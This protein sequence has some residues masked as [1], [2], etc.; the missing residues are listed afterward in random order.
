MLKFLAVT[1][2]LVVSSLAFAQDPNPT[3]PGPFKAEAEAGVIVV[4]GNTESESYAAKLLASYTDNGNTYS[5]FGKY[6]QAEANGLES[7]LNWNAG[8]RYERALSEH[9]SIYAGYK[10]ES[11]K[12]AGYLQRDSTDLGG[13]YYLVKQDDKTWTTELGYRYSKTLSTASEVSYDNYV[14]LYTEYNQSLDKTLSFKY[15]LEYLP[16]LT[17]NDQYLTNTEA[18][19]NVMLSQVFSL[20]LAYLLQYQN[21]P[22]VA[23]AERTEKTFTTTLVA[24]F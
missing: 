24:K 15:W 10:G 13:K 18:S 9:F 16:N 20:K 22:P 7:A 5:V 8:I 12:F 3:A 11:D 1:F 4:S 21:S 14:R 23:T 6:L 17:D 19:M 2:H